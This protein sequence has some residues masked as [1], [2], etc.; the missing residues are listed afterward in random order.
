MDIIIVD[1]LLVNL[2]LMLHRPH[3][4]IMIGTCMIEI[5]I[6]EDPHETGI[7]LLFLRLSLQI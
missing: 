4:E 5:A 2:D 7:H 1:S 6:T 3:I